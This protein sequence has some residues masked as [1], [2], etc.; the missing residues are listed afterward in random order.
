MVLKETTVTPHITVEKYNGNILFKKHILSFVTT[1][2]TG[3]YTVIHLK[4][5]TTLD[6]DVTKASQRRQRLR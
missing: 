4:L 1:I 3:I 2:H 5:Y 6:C